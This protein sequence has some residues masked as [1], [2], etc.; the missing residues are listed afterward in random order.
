MDEQQGKEALYDRSPLG[1]AHPIDVDPTYVAMASNFPLTRYRWIPGFGAATPGRSVAR[2][3]TWT[4]GSARASTPNSCEDILEDPSGATKR[5][6]MPSPHRIHDRRIMT[7][8]RPSMRTTSFKPSSALVVSSSLTWEQM[9]APV[10]PPSASR[11][12]LGCSGCRLTVRP[13]VTSTDRPSRLPAVRSHA[14]RRAL[15]R[16]V[17]QPPPRARG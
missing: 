7:R 4:D 5:A 8:L 17:R 16:S 3:P 13:H 11:P 2:L 6:S 12:M 9:K 14:R 10:A 15:G 1:S